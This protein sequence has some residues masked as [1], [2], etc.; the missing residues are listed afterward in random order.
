MSVC[1]CVCFINCIYKFA[2]PGTVLCDNMSYVFMFL[3]IA[4]SNF[5]A[6]ALAGKVCFSFSSH[7]LLYGSKMLLLQQTDKL[8]FSENLNVP[9]NCFTSFYTC[10][11]A[12]V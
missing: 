11:G 12:K 10:L 3:S 9:N 7:S 6:T 4:T 2:G 5:V 8:L 1:L